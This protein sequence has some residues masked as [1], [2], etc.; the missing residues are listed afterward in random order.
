MALNLAAQ[1]PGWEMV[2]FIALVIVFLI[3]GGIVTFVILSRMRWPLSYVV[4]ED[5]AGKGYSVSRKGKCR[6]IGFGDGGEEILLLKYINKYRIGY[7]KRIGTKQIA[8]AI[9]E[10][11]LWYQSSF[12][13][14]NKTLREVGILPTSVNIRLAMS[15]VR[16]GLE[17]RLEPQDWMA[18]YGAIVGMGLLFLMLLVAGGMM[19]Y[20]TQQQVKIAQTNAAAINSSFGTQQATQKTLS[21]ID[22]VLSKIDFQIQNGVPGNVT[23]GGSGLTPNS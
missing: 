15:A 22:N 1:L 23:I 20:S 8:W 3:V 12:G 17:K 18:K 6:I 10:D 2:L 5:V 16:K 7:G 13:D 19:W 14:L 21:L 9:G 11:G 4:L